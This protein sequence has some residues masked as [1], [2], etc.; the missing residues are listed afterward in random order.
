MVAHDIIGDIAVVGEDVSKKVCNE[1]LKKKNINVVLRKKGIHSGEF[2]TQK[3]E[4]ICGEA[5]KETI[6]KENGVE[7]KLDVERCY[8][9]PRLST[10]RM[11]IAN[12]VKDKEKILVFFS[13]VA[14]YCLVIAKNSKPSLIVGVEKNPIAHEYAVWN[15]RKYK[16][17]EL[18]NKDARDFE[19]KIKF[20]RVLMPLPK[21]ADDFLDVAFKFV[22]KKGIVHFYDFLHESEIPDVALKKIKGKIKVL[23][24]VKCG[25]YSPGKFRICVDFQV[26]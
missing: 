16:N 19:S 18:Y 23:K 21:S 11:R 14:P 4:I 17:I 3:L 8:F 5:R 2:R 25:Q 12:L 9:S 10:E 20:D 22:K 15:C 1:L 26:L 13:G 24:I 7:M 6:Y